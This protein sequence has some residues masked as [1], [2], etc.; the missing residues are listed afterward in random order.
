VEIPLVSAAGSLTGYR[1]TL[2]HLA[3]LVEQADVVVPG[4]GSPHERVTAL[5]ILDEDMAYLD[6][7]EAGEERPR[8]AEGRDTGRQR[9]IHADNLAKHGP[10]G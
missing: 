4:H 6:A 3:P 1:S 2:V 9:E 5:R 8:L 7:L 10:D